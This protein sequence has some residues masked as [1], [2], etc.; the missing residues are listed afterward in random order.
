MKRSNYE[1]KKTSTYKK[2]SRPSPTT[3]SSGSF[4]KD[5]TSS[6]FSESCPHKVDIPASYTR[7]SKKTTLAKN[8]PPLP[9]RAMVLPPPSLPT[10]KTIRYCSFCGTKNQENSY[11]CTQCGKELHQGAKNRFRHNQIVRGTPLPFGN[12]QAVAALYLGIFTTIPVLGIFLG[13]LALIFGL[14]G[15]NKVKHNPEVRG[16]AMSWVGIVIGGINCLLFFVLV[17]GCSML[18]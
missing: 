3:A 5:S 15:L 17:P 18:S 4:T 8:P 1:S 10:Q 13:L 9:N 7:N 11:K 12:P 2:R 6:A 14:I 16:R